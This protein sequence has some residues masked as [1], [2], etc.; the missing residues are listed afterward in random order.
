LVEEVKY[1]KL[2]ASKKLHSQLKA[3]AALNS[4]SLEAMCLAVLARLVE[5]KK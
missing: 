1:I 2:R 5:G 3:R 4:E